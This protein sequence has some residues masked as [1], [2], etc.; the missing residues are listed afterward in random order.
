MGSFRSRGRRCRDP[1]GAVEDAHASQRHIVGPE[2][3]GR[4]TTQIETGVMPMAGEDAVLDVAAVE[5]KAHVRAAVVERDDV[6]ANGDDK[7]RPSGRARHHAAAVTQLRKCADA[8]KLSRRVVQH[9]VLPENHIGATGLAIIA[10]LNSSSWRRV[11][12]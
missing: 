5:G 1:N 12:A 11:L 4:T 3:E 2:I 6:V 7:D 10:S 9:R 8:N